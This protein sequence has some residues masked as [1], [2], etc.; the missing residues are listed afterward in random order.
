MRCARTLRAE[1]GEAKS[2]AASLDPWR[3]L[4]ALGD[5]GQGG[6]VPW[7][8]YRG[9]AAIERL[10]PL[11]PMSRDIG[12]LHEL[13]KATTLYRMAMGQPRQAELLEVLAALSPEEQ[14]LVRDA[15]TLDLSPTRA[16]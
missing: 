2:V 9:P 3:E 6:M 15:V 5:D 1:F 4:F 12:R 13:V 10:V 14:Q 7:W 16:T 8:I 11:L